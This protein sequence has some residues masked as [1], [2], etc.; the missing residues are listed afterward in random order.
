MEKQTF[1]PALQ[2]TGESTVRNQTICLLLRIEEMVQIDGEESVW[3]FNSYLSVPLDDILLFKGHK[4]ACFVGVK[5]FC[6][7]SE[8]QT[9][10]YSFVICCNFLL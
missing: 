5:T 6:W 9:Y 3:F 2:G 7:L 1:K 10:E 4:T 8:R